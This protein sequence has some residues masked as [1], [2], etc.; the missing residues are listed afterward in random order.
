[1]KWIA[2]FSFCELG[3]IAAV[4]QLSASSHQPAVA[5]CRRCRQLSLL[6]SLLLSFATAVMTVR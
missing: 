5:S 2:R 4:R 1:M 3:A 6:L